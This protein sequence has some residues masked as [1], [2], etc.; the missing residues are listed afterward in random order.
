MAGQPQ[1]GCPILSDTVRKGGVQGHSCRLFPPK[2]NT[3]IP[4]PFHPQ[5]ISHKPSDYRTH[6]P[7]LLDDRF[8]PAE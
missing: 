2:P 8:H 3:N 5:Q 7:A 6:P 1:T 4:A